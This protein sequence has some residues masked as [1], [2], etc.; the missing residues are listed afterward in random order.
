[1]STKLFSSNCFGSMAVEKMFVK[2][3]N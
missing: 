3:L 2:T 1:M